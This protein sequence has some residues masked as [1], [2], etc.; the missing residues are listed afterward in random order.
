M[1]FLAP[2][3]C[4]WTCDLL[5]LMIFWQMWCKQ[6]LM[7]LGYALRVKPLSFCHHKWE[8]V[9]KSPLVSED[10]EWHRS[11]LNGACTLEASQAQE[12]P[13]EI[14]SVSQLCEKK[15]LRAYVI[16][17]AF[18]KSLWIIRI[19]FITMGRVSCDT[20]YEWNLLYSLGSYMT[21]TRIQS[22]TLDLLF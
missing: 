3:L 17:T 1:Y 2:W 9:L 10:W 16:K 8:Q 11:D 22:V 20:F 6:R 19:K 18:S 15:A 14:S 21:K 4:T 5:G 12:S 13:A 7:Q